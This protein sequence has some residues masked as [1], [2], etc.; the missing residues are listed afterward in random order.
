LTVP[1]TPRRRAEDLDNTP[2]E[3]VSA[4]D[5]GR[6]R[7]DLVALKGSVEVLAEAQKETLE[8]LD[9]L[10]LNGRTEKLKAVA[11]ALAPNL[12]ALLEVAH[13]AKTHRELAEAAG[14]VLAL[15]KAAPY[16]L[17][18]SQIAFRDDVD[19]HREAVAA[20]MDALPQLMQVL[21]D[22]IDRATKERKKAIAW[23]YIREILSPATRLGKVAIGG[24]VT[25]IM[26]VSAAITIIVAV[27]PHLGAPLPVT[28]PTPIVSPHVT[29]HITPT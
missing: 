13:S 26:V 24:L 8:R 28:S 9:R 20:L 10:D 15:A 25:L 29:P 21:P 22:V 3:F 2:S 11:D 14:P 18:D 17:S 5:V 12:D 6:F 1:S 27:G 19:E 23:G 16:L 7:R 4:R